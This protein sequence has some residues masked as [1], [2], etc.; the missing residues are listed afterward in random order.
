MED[1]HYH[2]AEEL[3]P[4]VTVDQ[5]SSSARD[6]MGS[7]SSERDAKSSI[8]TPSSQDDITNDLSPV[9]KMRR[10][11]RSIRQKASEKSHRAVSIL[12]PEESSDRA[13]ADQAVANVKADPAFNA[14]QLVDAPDADRKPSITVKKVTANVLAAA[15]HPVSTTREA[16]KR[17]AAKEISRAQRPYMS[18]E[19]DHA[20][21]EAH[22]DLATSR[23]HSAYYPSDED[24]DE[25]QSRQ[26]K[27]HEIEDHRESLRVAW[28]VSGHTDRVRIVQHQVPLPKKEWFREFD[29]H[30]RFLR[31]DWG[32]YIGHVGPEMPLRP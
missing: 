11:V 4:S 26:Q 23:S 12:K 32:K 2:E 6:S 10:K 18:A 22:D 19:D 24:S 25:T 8:F 20:L 1:E 28:A 16:V 7:T 3:L 15:V 21:L 13:P 17:R 29:E 5:M 14:H 30:G 31:L 27:I 9:S